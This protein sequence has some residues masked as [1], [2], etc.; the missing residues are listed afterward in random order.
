MTTVKAEECVVKAEEKKMLLSLLLSSLLQV[1]GADVSYT[2][3][4]P[5]EQRF[6]REPVAQTARLGERITLPCRVENKRGML[7]WT[8]DG[9]GLGIER[10]LTG[11]DRYRM[12]GEDEE[13]QL[14][15][16]GFSHELCTSLDRSAIPRQS[17]SPRSTRR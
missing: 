6:L 8:R 14:K 12:I 16:R 1:V 11:F 17:S 5:F 15:E 7:Q 10:N 2:T 9:F 4:A 13:G 3:V